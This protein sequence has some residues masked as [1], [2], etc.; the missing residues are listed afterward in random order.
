V[1]DR[2]PKDRKKDQTASDPGSYPLK[3]KSEIWERKKQNGLVK[4]KR[5][6]GVDQEEDRSSEDGTKVTKRSTKTWGTKGEGGRGGGGM[7]D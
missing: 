3:K 1:F 4:K 5:S 6:R 2:D 7:E